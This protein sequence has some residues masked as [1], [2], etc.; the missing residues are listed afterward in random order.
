MADD[1]SLTLFDFNFDSFH[2][3]IS[4]TFTWNDPASL[5]PGSHVGIKKPAKKSFRVLA[6]IW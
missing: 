1:Y 2:I 3:A 5:L 6:G 4:A